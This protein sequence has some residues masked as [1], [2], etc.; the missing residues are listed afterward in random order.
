MATAFAVAASL[1]A[2]A[3]ALV[4]PGNNGTIKLDGRP[5]TDPGVPDN[6]PHI[7]CRLQVEFFGFEQG[8]YTSTLTFRLHP[9]TAGGVPFVTTAFVGEDPAGGG[10]DL[11]AEKIVNLSGF[12]ADSGVAPHPI[13]GWHVKLTTRTPFSMGSDRKHKVFWVTPCVS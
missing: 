5:F 11:D 4:P 3:M 13:Q 9:P 8:D 7:A 1:S 12:L 10:T 6:E 2:P